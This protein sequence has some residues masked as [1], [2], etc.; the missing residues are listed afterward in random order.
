MIIKS[1]DVQSRRVPRSLQTQIPQ[2]R[3][4]PSLSPSPF[5]FSPLGAERHWRVCWARRELVS[6]HARAHANILRACA[7]CVRGNGCGGGQSSRGRATPVSRSRIRLLCIRRSLKQRLDTR[8]AN[9]K[10]AATAH[11]GEQRR[12][13][14]ELK[15]WALFGRRCHM[16]TDRNR[17]RGR[18]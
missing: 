17:R 2:A 4:E 3:R 7:P 14:S 15:E 8:M 12:A 18:R 5:V 6:L 10:E 9:M 11:E 16:Q 1:R 13:L